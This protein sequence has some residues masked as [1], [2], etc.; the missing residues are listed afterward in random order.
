MNDLAAALAVAQA[1]GLCLCCAQPA[2][3][4]IL[5]SVPTCAQCG[6]GDC[7]RCDDGED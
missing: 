3:R 2:V 7:P 6:E 5:G 4:M 1:R